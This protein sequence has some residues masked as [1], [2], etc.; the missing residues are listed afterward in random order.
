M[1]TRLLSCSFFSAVVTANQLLPKLVILETMDS[2]S[3][4]I[5]V[6]ENKSITGSRQGKLQQSRGKS[7][8]QEVVLF[9]SGARGRGVFETNV[10]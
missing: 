5:V 7:H 2:L 4:D 3:D 1:A 8:P 6:G 9:V 10:V